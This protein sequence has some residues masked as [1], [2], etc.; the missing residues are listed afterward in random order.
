[1][2]YS[3]L[4]TSFKNVLI[5]C[6]KQGFTLNRPFFTVVEVNPRHATEAAFAAAVA[7]RIPPKEKL[8]L[9]KKNNS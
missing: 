7:G 5:V 3:G 9:K 8:L 6:K 1:L 4:N 2:F